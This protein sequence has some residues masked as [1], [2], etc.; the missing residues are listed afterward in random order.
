MITINYL[1]MKQKLPA[2]PSAMFW[3]IAL[4]YSICQQP[5][6]IQSIC[7]ARQ[8]GQTNDGVSFFPLVL[9]YFLCL[10]RLEAGWAL[11]CKVADTWN[12]GS[13][14]NFQCQHL[15]ANP[16]N[17]SVGFNSFRLECLATHHFDFQM[18]KLRIMRK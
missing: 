4:H 18:W 15:D 16:H 3:F 6:I 2:A 13:L 9:C 5:R 17:I 11:T 8:G 14:I 12:P 1:P 10:F 7:L